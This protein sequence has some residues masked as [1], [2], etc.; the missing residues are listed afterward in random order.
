M[1]ILLTWSLEEAIETADSMKA[2]GYGMGKEV[3]MFRIKWID[4]IKDG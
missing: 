3:R 2:R 4:V 1:Q